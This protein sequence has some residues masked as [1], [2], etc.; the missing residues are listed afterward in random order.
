MRIGRR[1][2]SAAVAVGL[3]VG[4]ASPAAA[5]VSG[6][7]ATAAYP[8]VAAVE[9]LF[10]GLGTAKCGG[11][12]ITPRM[13]L[14]AA[15]CVSDDAAAPTPVAVPAGNITVRVG[16]T[17]R[18]TGGQLATGRRVLLHPDW[19]WGEPN[20]LPVSDLALVELS[21]TLHV[22]AMPVGLWPGRVGDRL[23]LLGWGLTAYPA[24]TLPTILQQRDV[25]RLPAQDC[26]GGFIGDGEICVGPGSCY[27]DSGAPALHRA[28]TPHG[29]RWV[30]VGLTSR[31]TDPHAPCAGPSV[32]TDLTAYLGWIWR[33]VATGRVSSAH[34]PRP[35][36]GAGQAARARIALLRPVVTR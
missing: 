23:R 8:G 10:P 16:S 9:I 4:V 33:T 25:N 22:S 20:G 26:T 34:L 1:S 32:Y 12:L 5:I 19:M 31:E 30:A 18:T 27:G 2:A 3:L 36:G 13:L 35:V 7:D 14:T 24:T 6:Q 15:H 29:V 11:A 17:D 21:T 28:A